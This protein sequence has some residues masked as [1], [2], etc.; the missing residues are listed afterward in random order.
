MRCLYS[1]PG[2]SRPILKNLG[3]L[4]FKKPKNLGFKKPK[5]LGF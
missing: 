1:V 2:L 5:N 4:G 3:V